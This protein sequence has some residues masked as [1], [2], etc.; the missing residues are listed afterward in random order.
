[1]DFH[2]TFKVLHFDLIIFCV[3]GQSAVLDNAV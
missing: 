3:L 1:V 2:Q